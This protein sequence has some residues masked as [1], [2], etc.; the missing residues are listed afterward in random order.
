MLE[1]EFSGDATETVPAILVWPLPA[2]LWA[3]CGTPHLPVPTLGGSSGPPELPIQGPVPSRHLG[4]FSKH[5]TC[6]LKS[7]TN[8]CLWSRK[9]NPSSLSG[10][11][12]QRAG[13][14]CHKMRATRSC[15]AFARW[16]RALL[17]HGHCSHHLL[18]K[19]HRLPGS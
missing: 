11:G 9:E 14:G 17:S 4:D 19:E 16:G 1:N 2:L 8:K 12:A 7:S 3:G 6:S 18:G 15:W 5:V 10:G 13:G